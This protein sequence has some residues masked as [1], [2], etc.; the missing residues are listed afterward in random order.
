MNVI[1]IVSEYNPFHNGHLYQIEKIKEMFPDSIIIIAMSGNYTQRGEISVINKWDKAKISID[2]GVDIVLEIPFLFSNQSADTFSYAA[3][4]MLNAFKIDTLVFGSESNDKELLFKA[5]RVQL[6]N[7]SFDSLVKSLMKNGENYPTSLNKAIKKMCGVSINES[8]DLLGVSY[9]KEILSN[10]YNIDVVPI[11]RT[12]SFLDKLSD[13]KIV[14][15]INI[16][17]KLKTGKDISKYL[18]IDSM[19]SI[20]LFDEEKLFNFLKYKIISEKNFLKRYHLVNEGLHTRI[21]K[22]AVNSSNYNELVENI[23]TRRFT[24]NKINRIL[25]NI[26]VGLTNDEAIKFKNLEY[27]RILGMSKNGQKYYSSIKKDNNLA[28]I[29]KFEKY[30]S[31]QTELR[32]SM[33][34]SMLGDYKYCD[35]ETKSIPYL[36]D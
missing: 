16:R 34:Y 6:S 22:A 35:E 4:K 11:K 15:A 8:N 20:K 1:G 30:E 29:T 24:Y 32:A 31:S 28:V 9:I 33:I 36:K 25:M 23:K 21:Y 17:E 10:N 18:P 13:E 5:A 7:P 27:V 12:N 2:H 3:L 14:S 26:L 19:N